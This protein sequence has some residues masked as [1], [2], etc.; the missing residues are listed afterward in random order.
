MAEGTGGGEWHGSI[1][2]D[3]AGHTA[4]TS[5]KNNSE[6]VGNLAKS[7]VEL[8][9]KL[10]EPVL[11]RIDVKDAGTREKILTKLGR[12]EKPEAYNLPDANFAATAHKVGL[13]AEQAK[14]LHDDSTSRASALA[15]TRAAEQKTAREAAQANLDASFKTKYGEK[16]DAEK[17]LMQKGLEND[18]FF[19][20]D[21]RDKL[22]E[23][24]LIYHP[25]LAKLANDLGH[26]AQEGRFL[27]GTGTGGGA[28]EGDI[29]AAQ[30]SQTKIEGEMLAMQKEKGFDPVSPQWLAKVA[31][32]AKYRGIVSKAKADKAIQGG[33]A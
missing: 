31:E 25:D 8:S 19:S 11:D 16:A 6:G 17:A 26:Y 32:R 15:A 30:A 21:L 24:G 27:S 3:V 33:A 18:K 20:K 29:A 1:P 13:T 7:Y 12:P 4:L 2:A 14:A 28:P 23:A 22:T 5:F 9:K 10:S